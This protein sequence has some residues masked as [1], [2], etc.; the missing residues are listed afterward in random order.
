MSDSLSQAEPT[1]QHSL[2]LT[3]YDQ[4]RDHVYRVAVEQS[5]DIK[6]TAKTNQNKT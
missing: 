3:G 4:T 1:T 2:G 5:N 6:A